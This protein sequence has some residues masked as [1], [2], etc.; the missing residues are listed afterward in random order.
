M[1][2]AFL[3]CSGA[4]QNGI[5]F[6]SL[7]YLRHTKYVEGYMVFSV[8]VSHT[9]KLL[10]SGWPQHL[11]LMLYPLSVYLHQ[12]LHAL[13]LGSGFGF[14]SILSSYKRVRLIIHVQHLHLGKSI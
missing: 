6:V 9:E 11:S 10:L 12:H 2:V 7:L 13:T 3:S 1:I 4:R 8:P 5:V 14:R